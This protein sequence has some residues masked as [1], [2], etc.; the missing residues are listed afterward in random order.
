MRKVKYYEIFVS[1]D[2]INEKLSE[3]W[4][5]YGQPFNSDAWDLN[6]PQKSPFFRGVFMSG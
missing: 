6:T 5:L 4:E 1:E 2:S 3:G